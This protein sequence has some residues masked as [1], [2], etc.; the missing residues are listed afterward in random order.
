M[1]FNKWGV[2]TDKFKKDEQA[3][4][5]KEVT[6]LKIENKPENK[7]EKTEPTVSE[8][9]AEE[10]SKPLVITSDINAYIHDRLKGQPK[11]LAD[12]KVNP[13]ESTEGWHALKLPKEVSDILKSRGMA[14]RWINKKKEWIDR[15]L[16]VRGWLIVNRTYFPEISRHNFTANGTI[17]R[18]DAILGF[19]PMERADRL[20]REPGRISTEKIKNLPVDKYRTQQSEDAKIGYYKPAL[21]AEKDGEMVTT[22]IQP[23][24]E[25]VE[26]T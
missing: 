24:V 15:A 12:I 5:V 26:Q 18:G 7:I 13:L 23:D 16:D 6:E 2:D 10:S 19:M 20:R 1:S 14:P 22:G 21:G 3:A 25:P 11:T 9:N 17:E 8:K 4:P